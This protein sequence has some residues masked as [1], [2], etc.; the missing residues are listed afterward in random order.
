M[1]ETSKRCQWRDCAET[2]HSHG[3]VKF[4]VFNNKLGGIYLCE[5]HCQQAR[6][7]GHMD[8]LISQIKMGEAT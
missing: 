3:E 7:T 2:G 5:K 8:V 1:E 6:R 4:V